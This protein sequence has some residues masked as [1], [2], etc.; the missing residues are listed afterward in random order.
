MKKIYTILGVMILA[1]ALS[2]CQEQT[3]S[4][5]SY[6]EKEEA[7]TEQ[8]YRDCLDKVINNGTNVKEV[9]FTINND[10]LEQK[11]QLSYGQN[12]TL[13]EATYQ[14]ESEDLDEYGQPLVNNYNKVIYAK[15][16]NKTALFVNYLEGNLES[17]NSIGYQISDT[18]TTDYTLS[19]D[20][21]NELIN[22]DKYFT[23]SLNWFVGQCKQIYLGGFKVMNYYQNVKGS[24][25]SVYGYA[26][27]EVSG[28]F[29]YTY[30]ATL[31]LNALGQLVSGSFENY[32]YDYQE[33]YEKDEPV[34]YYSFVSNVAITYG[35]K[36]DFNFDYSPYFINNIK[37]VS[38]SSY[39][40]SKENEV[41]L[42]EDV[43]FEIKDFESD[44]ALDELNYFIKEIEDP[45]M[46]EYE[47]GHYVAKKVG[48]TKVTIGN[49]YN[50]VTYTKEIN[51][52]YPTLI[53]FNAYI[54]SNH[55]TERVKFV[56]E[57]D[58][59]ELAFSPEGALHE[60]E[61]KVSSN[62]KDLISLSKPYEVTRNNCV[63]IAYDVTCLKIGTATITVT[64]FEAPSA[65]ITLTFEIVAKEG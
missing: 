24:E 46:M 65:K 62:S 26:S 16:D 54:V 12:M 50:D 6:E 17:S 41:C 25:S 5:P 18:E 36:E 44:K 45:T 63:Y 37:D 48:K 32:Q 39:S 64:P 3:T 8:D 19:N 11:G 61:V 47:N 15:K 31:N 51:I 38:F 52:V 57:T 4:S 27:Y 59:I 60:A 35:N 56:G 21:A 23:Y 7:L 10:N 22:N 2:N 53:G 43:I 58:T 20:Q 1:T 42:L 29:V 30:L 28:S 14:E 55:D 9:S 33:Y 13:L 40:S 49:A 34:P